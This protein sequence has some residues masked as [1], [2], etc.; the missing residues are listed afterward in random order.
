MN[1][2]IFWD[3]APCSPYVNRRLGGTNYLHLQGRKSTEQEATVQQ[4]VRHSSHLQ[5]LDP[6]DGGDMFLR[7]VGSLTDCME[8]YRSRWQYL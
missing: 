6:E 5:I 8:L 7:N 2:T 4:M 1:A 3:I